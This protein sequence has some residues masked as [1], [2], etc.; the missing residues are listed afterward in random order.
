MERGPGGKTR[1]GAGRRGA[2]RGGISPGRRTAA[3]ILRQV[4]AGRRLDVAWESSGARESAE[5]G[6]IRTLVFGVARL[7]GRL[8]F[9][10]ERAG[11]RRVEEL[12]D[13]VR[14]ALRMGAFQILAMGGVPSYAAVSE[15][16]EQMRGTK[17]RA[18]AGLV[19]A[20]LRRVAARSWSEKDFPCPDGDP[21][22][23]LASWGSHPRWLVRR[24]IGAFG[25]VGAQRLV[26]ANNREPVVHLRPLGIPVAEAEERLAAAGLRIE[27]PPIHGTIPLPPRTDPAAALAIAPGLI[28]DPA[29]SLVADFV[30]APPGALVADL[31][32]APGGKALAL[33]AGGARVL[34]ADRSPLRLRRVA[35]G[36][37]RL[38]LGLWTVAA[39]ARRPPLRRA[40]A[41]LLDVPCSGTGTLR[42][43]PDGRWRITG[44][45]IAGLAAVQRAL[46][47][48]AATTVPPGGL[49][50]Y[51]TCALEPE[52]NQVRIKD[53]LRR[54][55]D[56]AMEAGP[57]PERFLD[58]GGCLSILPQESGFDGAFAARLRRRSG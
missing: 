8:D 32:A 10:L 35:E 7:R 9:I 17:S 56:F 46:L 39:D 52:E 55:P 47:E 51:A 13:E 22:S 12:D 30:A 50:V 34:A 40:D 14:L 28:Q 11:G 54:H 38:D 26:E 20:I 36:G 42:R 53:F 33:A 43:H 6:W 21:E 44:P 15:A 49:L 48:G 3:R 29:A 27:A 37:A 4:E 5:R 2:R 41:V 45:T 58:A 57:A 16:V 18:A 23:Y 19:N 25:P 31:C 24:W 1:G